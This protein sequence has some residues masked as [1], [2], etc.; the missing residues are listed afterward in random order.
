MSPKRLVTALL[1]TGIALSL[2]ACN[3]YHM[4]IQ[5]GNVVDSKIASKIHKGMTKRQLVAKIGSPVLITPFK[6]NKLIYLYTLRPTSGDRHYRR[7]E[8]TLINGRV[9]QYHMYTHKN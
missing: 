8:V 5:Q 9:T 1:S 6:S 3:I 4:P 2:T 7:L